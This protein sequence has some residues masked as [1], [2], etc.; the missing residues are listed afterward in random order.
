MGQLILPSSATVYV[1][2]SIFIYSV[3]ANVDYYRELEPLWRQFDAGAITIV[4]SELALLE[5][6]VVPIRDQDDVLVSIYEQLLVSSEVQLVAIS[7]SILRAAAQLRATTGLKTPDAIHAATA[8][9]ARATLFLTNDRQFRVI[10]DLPV[11]V[12]SEILAS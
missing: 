2:T 9:S 4:S 3:E 8:I 1:D 10:S 6:L 12:L 5:T 11:V 7:Q